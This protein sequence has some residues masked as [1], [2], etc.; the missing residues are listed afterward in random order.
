MAEQREGIRW[1][2]GGFVSFTPSFPRVGQVGIGANYYWKPGSPEAPRTTVT[3]MLGR[4]TDVWRIPLGLMGNL[5]IG[6]TY[7]RDG[8]SSTDTLGPGTTSNVSTILPS[9]SVNSSYP[10]EG[11]VPRPDKAKAS[12]IEAGLSGSIGASRAA[13]YTVTPQQIADFL[14]KYLPVSAS[15]D[16]RGELVRDSAAAAGIPSRNNVFENGYPEAGSLPSPTY[17]GTMNPDKSGSSVFVNG[18][19]PVA[20]VPPTLQMQPRGLPGLIV[21]RFIDASNSTAP[22]AGGLPGLIQDHLRNNPGN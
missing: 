21:E 6:A 3:G 20:F 16:R 12:S 4:G 13:T 1:P 8:M 17:P 10:M 14:A 19:S 22:P 11:Y 2:D 7:L 15:P 5:N 18:A 9:V